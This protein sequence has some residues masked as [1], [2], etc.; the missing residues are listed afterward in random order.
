M[1]ELSLCAR[2]LHL[3]PDSAQGKGMCRTMKVLLKTVMQPHPILWIPQF[4]AAIAG[5]LINWACTTYLSFHVDT[6]AALA[7]F[8]MGLLGITLC[9]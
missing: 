7:A 6:A 9:T 8:C 4:F 2:N 3:L 1:V 5:H